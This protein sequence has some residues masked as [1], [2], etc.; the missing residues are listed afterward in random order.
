MTGKPYEEIRVDG[1]PVS[2]FNLQNETSREEYIFNCTPE[3]LDR[4]ELYAF[5]TQS[6]GNLQLFQRTRKQL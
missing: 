5:E 6:A 4:M 2:W 3:D 1:S